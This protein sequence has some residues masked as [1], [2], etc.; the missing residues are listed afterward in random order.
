MVKNLQSMKGPQQSYR[1]QFIS[2]PYYSWERGLNQNSNGLLQQHFP[3]EMEL[4]DLSD[5][6]VQRAADKL[7]HRSCQALEYRTPHEVFFEMKL[8]FPKRPLVVALQS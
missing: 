6:Q 2:H 7:N 8:R 3:K 1:R 5:E 4:A